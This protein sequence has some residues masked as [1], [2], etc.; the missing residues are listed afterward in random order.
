M[1]YF[2]EFIET[3]KPEFIY[4]LT[5]TLFDRCLLPFK[6]DSDIAKYFNS[7]IH[8]LIGAVHR[9][10]NYAIL[11]SLIYQQLEYFESIAITDESTIRG[12]VHMFQGYAA[13]SEAH[14]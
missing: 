6:V 3:Q 9:I 14:I 2:Q 10:K 7:M 13:N 1:G 8:E 12:I 5:K 4:E 11:Q